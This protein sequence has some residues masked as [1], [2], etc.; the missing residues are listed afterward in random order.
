MAHCSSTVYQYPAN[1]RTADAPADHA[2][3]GEAAGLLPGDQGTP[4][5]PLARVLAAPT[6]DIVIVN[7]N[8]PL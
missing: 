8:V 4:A 5:V 1:L 2:D 6:W 3:E 7:Y